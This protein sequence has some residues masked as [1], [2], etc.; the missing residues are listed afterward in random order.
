MVLI[1]RGQVLLIRIV[2]SGEE[3]PLDEIGR[4][5]RIEVKIILEEI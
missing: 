4:V 1:F 3:I 5:Q 2:M